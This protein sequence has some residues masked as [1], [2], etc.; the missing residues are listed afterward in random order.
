MTDLSGHLNRATLSSIHRHR[1]KCAKKQRPYNSQKLDL[2][3]KPF[4]DLDI[5]KINEK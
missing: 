1:K 4:V 2:S 3:V 5:V